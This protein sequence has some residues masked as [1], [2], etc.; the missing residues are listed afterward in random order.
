MHSALTAAIRLGLRSTGLYRRGERNARDVR[1]VEIECALPHL[2]A[3][4]DGYRLL[5][6]TDL[7]IGLSPPNTER[8]IEIAA[9]TPCDLCVMT[10]DFRPDR[11]TDP[12]AILPEMHR[13]AAAVTAPDGMFAVLGNHD[14]RRL[15]R[16]L[17]D[18][19]IEVLS[20]R[21]V[22]VRRQGE[23]LNVL[24]VQDRHHRVGP[25]G[26]AALDRT[27]EGFVVA[28]VHSPRYAALAARAGI[29]L[30]L[31]GHTHGGQIC[32]PGG[33][34]IYLPRGISYRRVAGLWRAGRMMGYTSRGAG[35]SGVP[36]RFNCPPEVVRF[37]L[38]RAGAPQGR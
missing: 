35:P 11:C 37:T 9:D 28:L 38:R 23:A 29:D 16:T 34:P 31:C 33:M 17:R 8:V 22:A 10:G 25:A 15:A 1:L 12:D 3:A 14:H 20:N 30:Y 2:P 24:G 5:H 19:G 13:I 21:A 4:F 7:H 32:L 27:P 26:R 6:L 18:A 36:V